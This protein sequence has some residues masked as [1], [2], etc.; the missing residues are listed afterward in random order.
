MTKHKTTG[1]TVRP[2]KPLSSVEAG[3]YLSPGPT[4]PS[5]ATTKD[6]HENVFND[7]K[8]GGRRWD[9]ITRGLG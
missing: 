1:G 6:S 8:F 3:K 7:N 2:P 4:F 9:K 5:R